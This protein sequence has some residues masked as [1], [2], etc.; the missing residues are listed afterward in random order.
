MPSALPSV[1]PSR[2]F[3]CPLAEHARWVRFAMH[4]QCSPTA[5]VYAA[6][7]PPPDSPDGHGSIAQCLRQIRLRYGR[8]GHTARPL[9]FA[10]FPPGRLAVASAG[11]P[12]PNARKGSPPKNP[13]LLT[14]HKSFCRHLIRN[15][16]LVPVTRA[17]S[18]LIA[19]FFCHAFQGVEEGEQS[20]LWL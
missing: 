13:E 10:P 1:R 11:G 14:R 5:L 9:R 2:L 16:R 17:L 8:S 19:S 18:P 6:L 4:C 3:P 12:Q 15:L 7:R 20:Q